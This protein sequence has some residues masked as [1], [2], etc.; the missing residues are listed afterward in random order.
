MSAAA[1]TREALADA[2][3]STGRV[4][5]DG[6]A[7]LAV[8]ELAERLRRQGVRVEQATL[9]H[10]LLDW[11]RRGIAEQVEPGRWRLTPSGV[12]RFGSFS[13]VEPD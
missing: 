4:A 7:S 12:R 3:R 13:M 8:A 10:W 2:Q 5:T 1:D 9:V 6:S 11:Q